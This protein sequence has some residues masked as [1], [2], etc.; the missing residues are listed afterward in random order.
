MMGKREW[1]FSG[2]VWIRDDEIVLSAADEEIAAAVPLEDSVG[3][4]AETRE[5]S[6][7]RLRRFR[8]ART[9]AALW[10]RSS[11]SFSS[12]LKMMRSISGG[13]SG[14]RRIGG[15]GARLRIASVIT[16]WVSP[17]NGRIPVAIS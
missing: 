2:I 6:R 4:V 3:T 17:R 15:A 9:S 12:S 13:R 8:S 7:S 1:D 10:Q 14:F 16:P 5:E 11:I